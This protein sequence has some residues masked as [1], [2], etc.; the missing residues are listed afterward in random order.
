MQLKQFGLLGGIGNLQG[1]FEA[2][3]FPFQEL[4]KGSE[5]L[6]R[7]VMSSCHQQQ[8][9]GLTC[10]GSVLDHADCKTAKPML[11]LWVFD[12]TA[13]SAKTNRNTPLRH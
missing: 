2:Q 13:S 11:T 6:T 7:Q 1:D 10:L 4:H 5:V 8:L 9:Q 3:V 12:C